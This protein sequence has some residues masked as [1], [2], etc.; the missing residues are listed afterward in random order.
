M[1][2]LRI[3]LDTQDQLAEIQHAIY[4]AF[5]CQMLDGVFVFKRLGAIL[6]AP[7]S[8]KQAKLAPEKLTPGLLAYLEYEIR[9]RLYEGSLDADATLQSLNDLLTEGRQAVADRYTERLTA[10]LAE[11]AH[12][13]PGE[14]AACQVLSELRAIRKTG[15]DF[16][17]AWLQHLADEVDTRWG[18]TDLSYAWTQSTRLE[19]YTRRRKRIAYQAE[20]QMKVAGFAPNNDLMRP[21]QHQAALESGWNAIAFDLYDHVRIAYAK[22]AKVPAAQAV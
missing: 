21:V 5:R 15:P 7:A 10:N 13:Y 4:G 12:S 9:D 18:D 22:Q 1:A 3:P 16:F 20:E 2:E 17:S 11:L 8:A 6:G 14:Q 19:K